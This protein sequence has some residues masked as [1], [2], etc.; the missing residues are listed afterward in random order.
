MA[1]HNYTIPRLCDHHR[2]YKILA[3]IDSMARDGERK[4]EK[5]GKARLRSIA[6][7]GREK[8]DDAEW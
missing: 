1:H 7:R 6:V 4:V 8:E 3:H 5:L 2:K